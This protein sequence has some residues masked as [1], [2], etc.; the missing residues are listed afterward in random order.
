MIPQDFLKLH[1]PPTLGIDA[2][3]P[4]HEVDVQRGAGAFEQAVVDGVAH[5]VVVE[6]VDGFGVARGLRV[7]EMFACQGSQVLRQHRAD[8]F[9]RERRHSVLREFQADHR[10]GLDRDALF[11]SKLV[12]PRLEQGVDRRR[13]D[14]VAA[15]RATHPVPALLA[16]HIRVEQHRQ[17]L[18]DEQR[19]AF[20]GGDDSA[21]HVLRQTGRAQQVLDDQRRGGIAE[22]LQHEAAGA[23]ALRPL[24]PFFEQIVAGGGEQHDG[25]SACGAEHVLEQ[26]EERRLGPV[27]V[28]DERNHRR[29][30]G[31]AFEELARGPVRFVQGERRR[32]EANRRSEPVRNAGVACGGEQLGTR[33]LRGVVLAD[34]G[35]LANDAAQRPERDAISIRQAAPAQHARVAAAPV[36]KLSEQA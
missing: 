18:L 4:A 28:V 16:Q 35:R 30:R 15:A 12:E 17:H 20:S 19:V 9:G 25:R 6:A 14:D 31:E 29:L 26:V 10:S 8:R 5:Q 21:D 24:R 1:D 33:C 3:R 32:A 11:A 7:D 34:A 2:V 13:H 36:D 23:L 22:W 27:D